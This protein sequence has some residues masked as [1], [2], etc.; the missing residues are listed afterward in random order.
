M[1][2]PDGTVKLIDFGIARLA[3]ATTNLTQAGYIIGTL[4]YM[5]PEIFTGAEADARTD[6]FAFGCTAYEFLS[7][8]HPFGGARPYEAQENPEVRKKNFA[9]GPAPAH[10]EAERNGRGALPAAISA[11]FEKALATVPD[12]RYESPTESQ[13]RSRRPSSNR[14]REVA[15]LPGSSS[16]I[17]G[18]QVPGGP[19]SSPTN[20]GRSTALSLSWTY[21]AW[22][23]RRASRCAF[24]KRLKAAISL[25]VSWRNLHF[26]RC[27][28]S[29]RSKSRTRQHGRQPAGAARVPGRLPVR[30]AQ[31]THRP[32]GRG[33]GEHCFFAMTGAIPISGRCA[34]CCELRRGR[35]PAGRRRPVCRR[36][37][38]GDSS[39]SAR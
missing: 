7:G 9:R 14:M 15:R 25:C 22:T 11:V 29:A 16:A 37:C 4:R 26:T 35:V 33:P 8:K 6:L 19:T 1:V 5:A 21:K 34:G 12:Q 13:R 3:A 39:P 2:L 17:N 31:H 24:R 32:L 36:C 30:P 23:R 18:K 20:S 28:S 38:A 10:R 27:G